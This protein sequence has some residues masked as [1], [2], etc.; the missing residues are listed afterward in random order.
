MKFEKA[1]PQFQPVTITL[2]T[3]EEADVLHALAGAAGGNM[4][5][6]FLFKL[7]NALGGVSDSMPSDY[8]TG[9]L[10]RNS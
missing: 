5:G 1:K 7:Y 2:E 8:W 4:A 10:T 3:Q 6:D 9:Y